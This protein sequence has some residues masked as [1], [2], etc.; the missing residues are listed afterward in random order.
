[1]G[2]LGK[3]EVEPKILGIRKFGFPF[4]PIDRVE[5]LKTQIL[6]Y[7]KYSNHRPNFPELAECPP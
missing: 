3:H 7:L 5:V 1:M 2:I 6:Q 4:F